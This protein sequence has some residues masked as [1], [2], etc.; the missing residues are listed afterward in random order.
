MIDPPAPSSGPAHPPPRGRQTFGDPYGAGPEREAAAGRFDTNRDA[1]PLEVGDVEDS[2]ADSIAGSRGIGK[3]R[4]HR[5]LVDPFE[6]QLER[7]IGAAD[8]E[9]DPRVAAPREGVA[10]LRQLPR[11]GIPEHR[12]ILRMD[13]GDAGCSFHG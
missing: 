1:V 12:M 4:R 10:N 7:L 2:D 9:N 13:Q 3:A 11:N 5:K 6:A 8:P